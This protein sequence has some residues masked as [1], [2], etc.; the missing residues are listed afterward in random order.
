[1][2]LA[3]RANTPKAPKVFQFEWPLKTEP[4]Q[5]CSPQVEQPTATSH[6]A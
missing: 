5:G 4:K 2:A 1:M 3:E 6:N